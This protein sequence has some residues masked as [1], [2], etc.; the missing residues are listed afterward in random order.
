[1]GSMHYSI[2]AF[3]QKEDKLWG[4]FV[5][6]SWTALMSEPLRSFFV[7]DLE[8]R[9][10]QLAIKAIKTF[11]SCCYFQSLKVSFCSCSQPILKLPTRPQ[12]H[13]E[14]KR[15][16]TLITQFIGEIFQHKKRKGR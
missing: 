5:P 7:A 6:L 11:G 14:A 1:M 10:L 2:R 4:V 9:K 13:R 16:Q 8:P 15:Q 12:E 3:W